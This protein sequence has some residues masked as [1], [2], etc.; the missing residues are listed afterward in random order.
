MKKIIYAI[1]V[2]GLA[3]TGVVTAKNLIAT[4]HYHSITSSTVIDHSGGT[5]ASGCHHDH[6]TGGYHCH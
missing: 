5:D 4:D 1:L 2:V 6:K 3:S